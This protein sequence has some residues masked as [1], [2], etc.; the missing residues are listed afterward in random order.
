MR[1][2]LGLPNAHMHPHS[3]LL[4]AAVACGAVLAGA[5]ALAPSAALAGTR[6]TEY[7]LKISE[8]E[9]TFPEYRGVGYTS[10]SVNT[11]AQVAVSIIRGGLTVYRDVQEGGSGYSQA[12]F[13]QVPQVGDEVSLESP[14]GN[15]IARVVYDGLPTLDPSV[16]AGSRNFS[17]E[18]SPG[19]IVE[20]AYVTYS[21]LRNPYGQVTGV[22]ESGFGEAQVKTLSGTTFGGSFLT[23]L[24]LGQTVSAT[25]T[26]KTPLASG[27]T[28]TYSSENARP[29]AACPVIPPVY[30]PVSAPVTTP[31][32]GSIFKVLR[33]TIRSLLKAGLRDQVTI[34]EAG[35]VVQDL[36]ASSGSPPAYAASKAKHHKIR[37]AVLL[38]RGTATAT[39]PG[40]VT[41]VLRA[42][43]AGRR[44]LKSAKSVKAVL[45]T[46]LTGTAGSTLHLSRRSVSLHH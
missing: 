19:D 29:V 22:H 8:G 32:A 7:T 14:V 41:V 40:T 4:R 11:N 37:H 3:R 45:L 35:K 30:T 42:T 28:Y 2:P 10:G 23:P 13:S 44:Q 43:A 34:D 31:L 17:G 5:N 26:L 39:G 24:T 9:T 46:T 21:L 27:A 18:N 16:C 33:G 25:E 20:G 38:A 15:L 1:M 36:Y 12:G 6:K